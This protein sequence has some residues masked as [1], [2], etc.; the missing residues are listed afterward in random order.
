[1]TEIKIEWD[2]SMRYVSKVDHD[3]SCCSKST[4][5]SKRSLNQNNNFM[6]KVTGFKITKWS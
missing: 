6:K 1:M 4:R 3:V 5:Q 2:K